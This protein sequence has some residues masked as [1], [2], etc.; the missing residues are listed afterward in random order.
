MIVDTA[1]DWAEKLAANLGEHPT[2]QVPVPSETIHEMFNFSP[3]GTDAPAKFWQM[4][5]E[6]LQA[7]IHANDPDPYAVAER[8][9]LDEVYPHRSGMA[10]LDTLGPEQRVARAEQ[11]LKISHGEIAKG[12][13]PDSIPSIVGPAGR[14]GQPS[15]ALPPG[16]PA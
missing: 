4:H 16:G 11:L 3:Y 5:E 15:L 10:L 7:A 6:L 14:P 9:A 12:N 13:P 2:D 8:G 1:Q